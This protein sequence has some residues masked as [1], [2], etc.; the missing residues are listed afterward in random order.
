MFHTRTTEQEDVFCQTYNTTVFG[1]KVKIVIDA[2][3][4]DLRKA[5]QKV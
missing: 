5:G 1:L 3:L 2:V 4:A